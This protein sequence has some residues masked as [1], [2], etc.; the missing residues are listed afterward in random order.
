MALLAELHQ[1][2][3]GAARNLD[4]ARRALEVA[5]L[6]AQKQWGGRVEELKS[7]LLVRGAE[8]VGGAGGGSQECAAGER[9]GGGS[10]QVCW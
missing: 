6:E 5:Y 2:R 9:E 8:A 7:A 1:V 10:D 3:R 4:D